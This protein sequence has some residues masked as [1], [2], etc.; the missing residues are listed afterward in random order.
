MGSSSQ[1]G[2]SLPGHP[3]RQR[4]DIERRQVADLALPPREN[5]H[6]LRVVEHVA[7]QGVGQS[8]IEE[9]HGAASLENT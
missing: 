1:G 9:H 7:D 2:G 6:R 5:D 8:G 3:L 4:Q